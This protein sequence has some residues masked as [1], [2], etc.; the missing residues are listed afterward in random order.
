MRVLAGDE[1]DSENVPT[2]GMSLFLRSEGSL[3]RMLD[4]IERE[5]RRKLGL[6]I[7]D[8]LAEAAPLEGET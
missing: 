5:R 4:V 3:Q 8:E 1:A 7:E 6:P 2:S